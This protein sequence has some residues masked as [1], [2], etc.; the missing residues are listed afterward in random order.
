DAVVAASPGP[1]AAAGP[2]AAGPGAAGPGAAGPG[3][4]GPGAAGQQPPLLVVYTPLH[5]VAG[6][7]AA[8]AIERAGYPPP[9]LVTAQAVPDPD[10][11]TLAFPNPEEPGTLDLAL[12]QAREAGADL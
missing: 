1:P 11:P 3:A 10:F 12:A 8:R 2:G 4:A 6:S 9:R 5:G 7:L